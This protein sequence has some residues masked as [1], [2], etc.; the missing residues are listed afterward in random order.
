MFNNHAG[1]NLTESK[2]QL[3]EICYKEDSFYLENVNQSVHFE[4]LTPDF[5]ESKII[6]ILQE[7]FNKLTKKKPLASKNISFALPNNFFNIFEVPFLNNIVFMFM[8]M[9]M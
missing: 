6:S 9:I 4:S 3:V 2:L 8:S 1:I 5:P 7:S